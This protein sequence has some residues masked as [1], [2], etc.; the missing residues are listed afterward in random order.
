MAAELFVGT[1]TV[2]YLPILGGEERA[3]EI[4][5]IISPTALTGKLLGIIKATQLKVHTQRLIFK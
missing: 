3:A 5:D 4:L 1:Q 2:F